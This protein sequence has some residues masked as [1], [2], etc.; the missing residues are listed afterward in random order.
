[1]LTVLVSGQLLLYLMIIS[2]SL[3]LKEAITTHAKLLGV[4]IALFVVAVIVSY[5]QSH[6]LPQVY[7]LF[8]P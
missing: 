2:I 7:H 8:P 3:A 6:I 4:D 5:H 1:M